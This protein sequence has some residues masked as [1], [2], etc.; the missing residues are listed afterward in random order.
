VVDLSA[1]DKWLSFPIPGSNMNVD[2]HRLAA[3]TRGAASLLVRFP[4]GWRRDEL[5]HYVCDEEFIVLK[6]TLYL[7][8]H[9]FTQGSY[10]FVPA[11][12]QRFGSATDE[13]TLVVAW[14]GAHP[15]WRI[16][17]EPDPDAQS[18]TRE[19]SIIGN[20]PMTIRE[21]TGALPAL[22]RGISRTVSAP[23]E[24]IDV[25]NLTW[26]VGVPSELTINRGAWD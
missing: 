16:D 26:E 19:L 24:V 18:K 25:Q 5:G 2:M 11:G 13:E 6:G 12:T 10:G 4:A 22:V 17:S 20:S 3:A 7:S 9:I 21:A 15:E 8:G 1:V 14:F 23:C